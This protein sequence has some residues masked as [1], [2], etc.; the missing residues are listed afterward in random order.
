MELTC[1]YR[2]QQTEGLCIELKIVSTKKAMDK[3][4]KNQ[5]LVSPFRLDRMNDV[6]RMRGLQTILRV[7]SSVID[8]RSIFMIFIGPSSLNRWSSSSMSI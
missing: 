8:D 2:H 6:Y 7:Y 5:E 1:D 4:K 3:T